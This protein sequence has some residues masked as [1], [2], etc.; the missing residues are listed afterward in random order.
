MNRVV[1]VCSRTDKLHANRHIGAEVRRPFFDFFQR[2]AKAQF[3]SKGTLGRFI[4]LRTHNTKI[5]LNN[6]TV[7]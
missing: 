2:P 3:T 4:R 7:Y 1:V 5:F 6:L